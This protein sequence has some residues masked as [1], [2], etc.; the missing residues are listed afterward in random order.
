MSAVVPAIIPTSR[1]ELEHKL[2]VLKGLVR[3][4]QIDI[5]DGAFAYPASW[6]YQS[7]VSSLAGSVNDEQLLPEWDQF[8]FEIDAMVKDP[9]S[10]LDAFVSAGA[11]RFIFHIESVKDIEHVLDHCCQKYDH[12]KEFSTDLFSIGLA[13][14]LD[15]DPAIVFPHIEKVD[16]IQVMGIARIGVQGQPFDERAV[17]RVKQ[18]RA[19]DRH[20]P[21]Q[22]DGGVTPETAKQLLV[23]GAN[24]LIVGS[25]IWHADDIKKEIE[26][27]DSLI[28]EYGIYQ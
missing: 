23:A 10:A 19:Y 12:D 3:R 17:E 28:T 20:V 26:V 22:V 8:Q 2:G 6:P 16:F 18:I 7:G 27:F 9:T 14:S 24:N 11:S 13:L 25:D 15:T 21:I 1:E 5:V 4:V